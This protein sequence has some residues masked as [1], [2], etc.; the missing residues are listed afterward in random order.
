MAAMDLKVGNSVVGKMLDIK[1][2]YTA[3][4]VIN[5]ALDGT[6]YVQTTGEKI[7]RYV[8]NV[9]CD[10]SANRDA[11][12]EAANTGAQITAIDRNSD[13]IIGFVEE[14]AIAWKEWADGHGVGKFT[15]IKQ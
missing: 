8:I 7:T 3:Q 14:D 2:K 6:V 5:T 4:K 15:L 11:L 13:S 9:Y 1:R 12:D 10:T